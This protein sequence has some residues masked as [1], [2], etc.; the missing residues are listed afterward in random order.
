M[1][2]TMGQV[3]LVKNGRKPEQTAGEW[4]KPVDSRDVSSKL[5]HVA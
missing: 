1:N 2:S 3:A 5:N 4:K